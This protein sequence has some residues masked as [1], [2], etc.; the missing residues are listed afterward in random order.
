[1]RKAAHIDNHLRRPFGYFERVAG[2]ILDLRL[3]AFVNGVERNEPDLAESRQQ[4]MIFQTIEHRRFDGITV[5]L[6]RG[7]SRSQNQ[8]LR[9]LGAEQS[10]FTQRELVLRQRTRLVRTKNIHAG[11]LLDGLEPC[12]DGFHPGERNGTDGHGDREH[13]GHR[14]R[15]GGHDQNQGEL[16]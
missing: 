1:M 16:K 5:L 12:Q 10:G 8:L 2:V 14:H 15:D 11:H 13:G 4:R 9:I 6:F 7:Q 3:G